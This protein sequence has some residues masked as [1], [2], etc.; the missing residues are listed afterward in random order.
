MGR[1]KMILLPSDATFQTFVFACQLP[2]SGPGEMVCGMWWPGGGSLA[3]LQK[4]QYLLRDT[5]QKATPCQAE[6]GNSMF[7]LAE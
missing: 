2:Q 5:Q 6:E 3:V 7:F 1:S 4:Q